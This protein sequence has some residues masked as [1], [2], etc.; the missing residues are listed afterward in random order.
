MD[1]VKIVGQFC[2][3]LQGYTR[4]IIVRVLVVLERKQ[5]QWLKSAT[6]VENIVEYFGAS[7]TACVCVCVRVCVCVCVRARV[8]L[9]AWRV[10][11]S[12]GRDMTFVILE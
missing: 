12:C 5:S 8:S 3:L 6:F 4:D 7:W 9:T 11:A 10:L 1:C 2:V